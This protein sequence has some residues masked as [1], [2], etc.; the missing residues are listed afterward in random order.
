L[1]GAIARG[2]LAGSDEMLATLLDQR[3][4]E[5]LAAGLPAGTRVAHKNGWVM[6][7]RHGAGV[8]FPADAPPFVL[9]VCL[10]TPWALNRTDDKA[11]QI[12]S[13]IAGAAWRTGTTSANLKAPTFAEVKPPHAHVTRHHRALC[14]RRDS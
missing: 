4:T 3:R 8:V 10:T 13:Q 6:G 12:V 7:V 5:D 9:A 14:V 11:C 2:E 1:F